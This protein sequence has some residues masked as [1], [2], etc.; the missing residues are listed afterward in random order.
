MNFFLLISGIIILIV[1]SIDILTTILK[2]SGGGLISNGVSRVIWRIFRNLGGNKARSKVLNYA[3]ISILVF[4]FMSWVFAL[5][6]GYSLIYLSD[7]G[8][9]VDTSTEVPS[10]WIGKIYY[11]GYSLTSL[12]NGDLKSG[13]DTWRIVSNLMGFN[14]LFF[15]SL[16]ISYYIPVLDAIIKKRIL[17]AYIYQVG[18][19][20]LEFV[21]NSWDGESFEMA[22]TE[23]QTLQQMIL[24][25]S[26]NHLAYPILDYF[27][28]NDPKYNSIRNIAVLDEAISIVRVY[29][30]DKSPKSYYWIRM[31]RSL[32]AYLNETTGEVRMESTTSPD[33]AYEKSIDLQLFKINRFNP[34]L[35]ANLESRRKTLYHITTNDGWTW[36]EVVNCPAR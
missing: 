24:E 25:H 33:F 26:E 12:G 20:P 19:T 18:S 5:W 13:S 30:L 29:E 28:S 14:A 3:G 4:L 10:N 2:L 16:A 34:D 27:H 8:S 31:K 1:V 17:A 21:E 7:E 23:F 11:V 35:L 9:V 36:D 32:D 22:Y 15:L 6:L